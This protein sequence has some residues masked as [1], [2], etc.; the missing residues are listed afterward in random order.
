MHFTKT[1]ASVAAFSMT[2]YAALPVASIEFQS[3]EQCDIGAPATGTPKF[4]ADITATPV[5]CDKTPVNREWSINNY[6]FKAHLDTKDA[7]LCHGL[8]VWNND[9]CSGKP[10]H[11][12]PFGGFGEAIEGTCLPDDLDTGYVS[13][14]LA[15][16]G[17]PSDF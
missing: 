15:C 4:T 11:F 12:V 5:T 17:F 6:A 7:H 16:E 3:W 10:K 9:G 14:K 8:I 13:F 2:A 1:L